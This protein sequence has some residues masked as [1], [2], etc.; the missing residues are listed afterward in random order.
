M[1]E[2]GGERIFISYSRKDGAEFADSLRQ[3]LQREN[4]SV[5]QDLITLEGG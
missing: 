1:A 2:M 4:L 5:W 3:R